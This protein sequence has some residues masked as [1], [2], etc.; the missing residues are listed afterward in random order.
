MRYLL[1]AI[2][3]F[4]ACTGSRQIVQDDIPVDDRPEWL[5]SRPVSSMDYIGIG[6][7][8]KNG[9]PEEYN[10][11]ARKQA[12]SDMASEIEVRVA[13]NSLLHTLENDDRF[14]E[15]Y[16]QAITTSS[17]LVLE[18]FEA[19]DS[20]EDERNYWVYYRLDKGKFQA[21]K[22]ERKAVAIED[23]FSILEL[24]R[25]ARE[26]GDVAQAAGL[27][28]QC[29][30]RLKPYWG[31]SNPS[32]SI[33]DGSSVDRKALEELMSLRNSFKLVSSQDYVELGI[34]NDF[35][36]TVR[37]QSKIG[38]RATVPLLL[39]YRFGDGEKSTLN[40]SEL[41][42]DVEP[43]LQN[44]TI[45]SVKTDPFESIRKAYL[46]R[47]FKFVRELLDE[48]VY[49]LEIHTTYPPVRIETIDSGASG[50]SLDKLKASMV[51]SLNR[52]DTGITSDGPYLLRA[53]VQFRDGGTA[54]GF[55][56]QYAD[57]TIEAVDTRSDEIV[58]LERIEGIKGVHSSADQAKK[59]SLE[60]MAASID[61]LLMKALLD[62]LF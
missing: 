48:E 5:K 61:D 53:K 15:S 13:S 24:A 12:L 7:A 30:E 57:A 16:Q 35:E 39:E 2:P 17:D 14:N 18:G 32:R 59:K 11:I 60:K 3:L 4:I 23:A 41:S 50:L 27:F 52:F 1:L 45:L 21:I 29:M 54:Q 47:E 34:A 6:R 55:I 9:S 36:E 38:E 28:V 25:T 40:T 62:G 19:W 37:I 22:E 8:L 10:A 49:Q 43:M 58:H 51:R 56:V 33:P 26:S 42:L 46:G 31:E 20:W 44:P